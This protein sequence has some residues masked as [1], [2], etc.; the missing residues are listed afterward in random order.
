MARFHRVGMAFLEVDIAPMHYGRRSQPP[1]AVPA[2][3]GGLRNAGLRAAEQIGSSAPS[4]STSL[5][6][7]SLD[8]AL[9]DGLAVLA[10]GG[11]AAVKILVTPEQT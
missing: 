11:S 9:D 10:R 3:G 2:P 6:R 1:Y 5:T 4:S 7:V 8:A